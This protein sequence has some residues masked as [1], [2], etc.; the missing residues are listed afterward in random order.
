MPTPS[1]AGGGF[2]DARQNRGGTGG[3]DSVQKT[4]ALTGGAGTDPD[5]NQDQPI[6]AQVPTG[7]GPNR[8]AWAVAV[9]ALV[10]AL[11]YAVGIFR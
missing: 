4:T 11:V 1:D 7:S 9:I 5:R 6:I 3:A 2:E 8:G 10:S